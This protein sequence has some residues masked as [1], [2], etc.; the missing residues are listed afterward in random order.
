MNRGLPE[1]EYLATCLREARQVAKD[2]IIKSAELERATREKLTK[3]NYLQEVIRGWYLLT[4]PLGAGTTTLWY[5]SFWS[6]LK[7]YL[8]DRFGDDGY[9]LSAE[10]S[11][12]LYA[13]QNYIPSQVVILTKKKTNAT[14][15]LLYGTSLLLYTDPNFPDDRVE[16]DGINVFPLA[17]AIVSLRPSY[18]TS[19]SVNAQ[20][21]L[22]LVSIVDLSRALLSQNSQ[23][24]SSRIVSAYRAMQ[25]NENA[26]RLEKDLDSIG[27][28]IKSENPFDDRKIIFDKS[29]K[30][31]APAALRVEGL[32]KKMRDTVVDI[33][34]KGDGDLKNKSTLQII[35][36]IYNEDAYHSLSIEGY[37]VTK[38]LIAKVA[39]NNFR[40]EI[41]EEDKEQRNA[42]AAKGY[43]DCFKSV[44]E[45]VRKV[46]D[47]ENAGKVFYDDLQ[48][49]YRHLFTPMVQAGILNA[50]D[51]A[52]YR[53]QPIYI[54]GSSH[55]PPNSSAVL[56]CMHVLE[57]FL[58]NEKEASARA[59]LGHFF[60]G[61][62]HPYR[63][64]NGRISR[65]LMN[66]NLISGGYNWTV[67]RVTRRKQY[68]AAL[69][70]ASSSYDIEP[71][72]RFILEEIKH[73]KGIVSEMEISSSSE[74]GG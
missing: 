11:L 45:S 37:Q 41:N 74:N 70:A 72:T 53:N 1:N 9:C 10:S 24:A 49:W 22:K 30:A 48:T 35:E 6:F 46:I 26:N 33:F 36:K 54:K 61:Y 31:N 16:H 44:Y 67:I 27:I 43:Y 42:L 25:F 68:L 50:G 66:L 64:G 62:I 69:E 20:I 73:W 71:F 57:D 55:V 39:T 34:P 13:S 2:D 17:R 65:F 63:D 47:G 18:F 40:P 19:Q 15:N 60:L 29:M 58:C 38:E 59:V 21:A 51:L 8:S 3:A 56:D 12:D 4:T 7:H 32:I 52:G 23:V 5:G 28:S 14:V